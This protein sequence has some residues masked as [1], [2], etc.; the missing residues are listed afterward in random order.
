M[1]KGKIQVPGGQ[2]Y[3]QLM[4]KEGP[5]IPVIAMHGGPGGTHWGLRCLQRLAG[6][7]PVLIYDQL[8]SGFSDP[9]PQALW[10]VEHFVEELAAIRQA[11]G[12]DKVFLLG[13]S[14]GTM[15]AMAYMATEPQ[16]VM[17][18]VLSG[19]CLKAAQWR[20]DC[21]EL[22]RQLPEE[23]RQAIEKAEQTG[24]F[25]T[26]DYRRAEAEFTRRFGCRL[27]PWP[28][29]K[30]P[31]APPRST[32]IYQYMWGPSEFTCTG[33]LRSY[34]ATGGLA[35]LR[36]PVLF[37]CGEYDTARPETVK[38][39]AALC[40]RAQVAVLPG[41]SHAHIR[42][43]TEEYCRLVEGFLRQCEAEG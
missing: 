6:P 3:Y 5:G 4:G 11:M 39:Q 31:E 13:Q 19:P 12:Y 35:D 1:E 42:E 29:E 25:D 21:V 33:T 27:L 36:C 18:L 41:A 2:V 7:R 20:Q 16:G 17:G 30:D 9:S 26:E 23:H 38:A 34:D 24:A 32:E 14:W 8:G 15:L 40:P 22:A 43:C 28:P 37:T 10:T